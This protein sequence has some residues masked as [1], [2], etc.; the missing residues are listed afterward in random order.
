MS[1][2]KMW[3]MWIYFWWGEGRRSFFGTDGLSGLQTAGSCIWKGRE[4]EGKK[5]T[6][7]SFC[8]KECRSFG[9]ILLSST[10]KTI[11]AGIWKKSI[12]WQWAEN[13]LSRQWVRRCRCVLGRYPASG[14]TAQSASAG[15]TC[16]CKY[17]NGDRKKCGKAHGAGRPCL[18]I[19]YVVWCVIQGDKDCAVQR[20]CNG[21]DSHVQRRGRHSPGRDG[22]ST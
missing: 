20:L 22:G 11:P 8:G 2:F 1:K 3:C 15:W 13:L 21:R 18:H 5:G 19:P 14:R 16:P 4:T 6:W 10:G 12:K 17:Q 9:R 7:D